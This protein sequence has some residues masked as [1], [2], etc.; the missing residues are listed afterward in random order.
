[1]SRDRCILG[2]TSSPPSCD[3]ECQFKNKNKKMMCK[4]TTRRRLDVED[5][6]KINIPHIILAS[7]DED[8]SEVSKCK[9]VL[10]GAKTGVV[11]TYAMH[12]GW[13]KSKQTTRCSRFNRQTP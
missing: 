12:H 7:K 4:L 8:A 9:E 6:K 5:I 3:S 13:S 10:E 2:K 11:E 1:M